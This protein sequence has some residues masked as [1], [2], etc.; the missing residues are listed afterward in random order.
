[1]FAMPCRH[2]VDTLRAADAILLRH[3]DIA[4]L[5]IQPRLMSMLL[6]RSVL[7]AIFHYLRRHTSLLIDMT[8]CRHA[9]A[10]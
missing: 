7:S 10:R 3:A 4:T 5:H 1:M 6:L 8:P 2:A 9:R